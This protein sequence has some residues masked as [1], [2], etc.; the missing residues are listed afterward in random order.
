MKKFL[1]AALLI[2]ISTT[3][4]AFYTY[5]AKSGNSYSTIGNTTYGSNARNGTNWSSTTIGSQT[6]GTD[7]RGNTWNYDH[8]TGYYNNSNGTTCF[9]KGNLR[10]CN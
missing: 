1:I 10:T 2:A 8:N 7:S 9:G 3:A 6:Y 4:S 5:D